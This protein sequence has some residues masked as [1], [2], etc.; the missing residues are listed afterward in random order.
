MYAS[1]NPNPLG[2]AVGDCTVRA[3][4]KATNQ[5]WDKAFLEL[6]IVGFELADM[7]S[8]NA[9]WGEYLKRKGFKRYSLP[10]D[11]ICTVRQF[12][13]ENKNGTFVLALSG[14]VVAVIDGKYCDAWDSGN[15]EVLYVWRRQK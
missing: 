12:A 3:I 8:A 4:A 11:D 5:T 15:E 6:C 9:V 7:P 13:A 1:Y 10:C 2:K 14:H